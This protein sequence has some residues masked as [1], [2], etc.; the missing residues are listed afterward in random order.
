MYRTIDNAN[1][2]QVMLLLCMLTKI[3]PNFN[4]G[5]SSYRKTNIILQLY[6]HK[7]VNITFRE[8]G[9]FISYM[10]KQFETKT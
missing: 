4:E 10:I 1:V 8:A 3:K 6:E 7:S 9:T 2:V 5:F